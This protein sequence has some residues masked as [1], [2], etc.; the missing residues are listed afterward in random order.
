[1]SNSEESKQVID[2]E[3][4]NLYYE[5]AEEAMMGFVTFSLVDGNCVYAN[6]LARELLELTSLSNISEFNQSQ[7][8]P[9]TEDGR[10]RIRLLDA[11]ITQLE[12]FFQDIL[13][14]K[15][16]GHNFIA[17][18]GIKKVK[19]KEEEH[20]LIM[21]Q[22]MTTQNKLKK[23]ITEKQTAIKSAYEEVLNQ[24]RQLKELDAAKDKFIALTTHE[25]RTPLAAM[26]G[27]AEILKLGLYESEEELKEF[28]TMIHDQGL[29]LMEL[30][31]DI[32]DFAKARA[33][34][35]DYFIEQA[36]LV[37]FMKSQLESMESMA[38]ESEIKLDFR[39]PGKVQLCYFDPLRLKQ[40]TQ[41]ILSNAI[42]YNRQGGTRHRLGGGQG[43]LHADVL[44]GYWK[45]HQRRR[46]R[47][48]LQ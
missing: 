47:S 20:L 9:G 19:L 31:N 14:Q 35:M 29:H 28:I 8:Y 18:I 17:N 5:I 42:K 4:Q 3:F 39:H 44:S 25:L 33:G 11:E 6:K 22:D 26:F 2:H 13:V 10:G 15:N 43:E 1:M 21:L 34:R 16:N 37:A 41:N 46:C 38:T 12:G 40:I 24:N 23:E 30:V 27:S 45:W 32:L 36:D 48:G 7:L